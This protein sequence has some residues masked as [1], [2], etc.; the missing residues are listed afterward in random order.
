MTLYEIDSALEALVDEQTGELRDYAAWQA[1]QL[2]REAKIEGTALWLK[3]L[4][5]EAKA[6][7]SE[8]DALQKRRRALE[9]RAEGLRRYLG[10]ALDGQTFSTPRC[11]ISWRKSTALEVE[12]PAAA[13]LWLEDH[14]HDE[15]VAYAT[16]A[17][18]KRGVAELVAQGADIPGVALAERQHMQV[19]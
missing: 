6:I 14:G 8:V 17:L 12:D 9:H 7:K 13:A 4:T 18:D 16:P 2:A 1:L 11:A 3:N 15:M 19:R 5:A 10:Q